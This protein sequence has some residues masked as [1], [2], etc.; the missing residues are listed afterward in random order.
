MRCDDARLLIPQLLLDDLDAEERDALKKHLAGCGECRREAASLRTLPDLIREAGLAPAPSAN[1][2]VSALA[3]VA[4]EDLATALG[5]A[6]AP[7]PPSDLKERALARALEPPAAP[8][9]RSSAPTWLA[10]AAAL[11]AIGFAASSQVEMQ[12]L[13]RQVS[14][15]RA[16]RI[17]AESAL[18]PVGH[19][20][21]EFRL[22]DHDAS[23]QGEL[24]H[25]RHDNFRVTMTLSDFEPSPPDQHYELWLRGPRGVVGLGTFRIDR[26]DDL[27][28]SFSVGVDPREFPEVVATLEPNDGDPRMSDHVVADT[29]L[30]RTAVHPGDYDD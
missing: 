18:G 4:A 27:T 28:L 9:R 25:L 21:Q 20:M 6:T 13:D 23:A 11:I 2:K 7:S 3:R 14:S 26:P 8:R 16:M 12:D 30:D 29:L 1:L 10:A 5:S 15:E 19:P 17:R 24:V 22:T